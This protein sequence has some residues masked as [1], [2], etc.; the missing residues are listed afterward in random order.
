MCAHEDQAQPL[1]P[2]AVPWP[3]FETAA[4][5][6]VFGAQVA[7]PAFFFL[8]GASEAWEPFKVSKGRPD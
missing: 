1:E 7:L 6:V 8:H 4:F 5:A 3:E 2:M